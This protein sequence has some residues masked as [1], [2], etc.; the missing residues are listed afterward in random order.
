MPMHG[1]VLVMCQNGRDHRLRLLGSR[2][3]LAAIDWAVVVAE[4]LARGQVIS[5]LVN[6]TGEQRPCYFVPV[7]SD[8][9]E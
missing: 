8:L 7:Q 1:A 6:R 5:S 2:E 4:S 9:P 3:L